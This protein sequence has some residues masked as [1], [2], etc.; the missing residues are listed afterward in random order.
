MRPRHLA[1]I[2]ALATYGAGQIAQAASFDCAKATSAREHLICGTPYL[3]KM[4]QD[5]GALYAKAL[6]SLSPEGAAS[7]RQSEQAW[8]R[9]TDE[10]CGL[11]PHAEP[12]A[13][14]GQTPGFCL[15]RAYEER[16][17]GIRQT[18]PFGPY[19]FTRV[20]TYDVQ[21][22]SDGDGNIP[23][24]P[25]FDIHHVGYPQVDAPAS[26]VLVAWNKKAAN[27]GTRNADIKVQGSEY[28]E[29]DENYKVGLAT[30][31]L[32][33]LRWIVSY[34]N[35]GAAHGE[36]GA[37]AWNAVLKSPLR[38]VTPADLFGK[39]RDWKKC[40]EDTALAVI[41]D[42]G[43]KG[44]ELAGQYVR[45]VIDHPTAWFLRSEGLDVSFNAYD[46]GC[47][48]CTPN[49]GLVPWNKLTSLLHTK[50]V[51]RPDATATP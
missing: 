18:G 51:P 16:L 42:H 35:H 15:A 20:D 34:Y 24:A 21:Q 40:L 7:L 10:V 12:V 41:K 30:K 31:D 33:S 23:G 37:W 48:M 11:R 22:V 38:D 50:L 9:Y 4:D 28:D 14:G 13:S 5:L 29:T 46:G 49:N 27:D 39:D 3:S 17:V 45:E 8:F 2:L 43:W 47:Y 1:S 26:V 32:I 6:T 19:V 36:Y 25:S 44:D